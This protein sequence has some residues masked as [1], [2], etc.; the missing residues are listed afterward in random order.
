MMREIVEFVQSNVVLMG[1]VDTYGDSRVGFM[2]QKRN[3]MTDR[4]TETETQVD[5]LYVYRG[6]KVEVKV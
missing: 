4:R 1:L 3:G 5:T 6:K 2:G